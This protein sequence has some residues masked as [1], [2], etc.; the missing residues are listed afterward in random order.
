MRVGRWLDA[1]IP[2]RADHAVVLN[3]AAVETL[4]GFGCRNVS[5]VPPGLDASDLEG[6]QA[7]ELG[8]GPW[9]VY[10]GNPDR[11]QDLDVLVEAM[12]LLP[13]VGLLMVSAS[14]LDD[15]KD[16]G[17]KRLQLVQT[18]DFERVK[19]LVAAADV[20][21]IPRTVCSG[22][23]IKLLNSLGLGVP[24][25][26]A[27]GSSQPLPGV[28]EVPNGD[29]PEMA[30]AI[31]SLVGDPERLIEL[32]ASARAHIREHCTWDARARELEGIYRRVVSGP[33]GQRL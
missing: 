21:A 33:D 14:P 6:V 25:V 18:G 3:A 12:R 10:A 20:A 11:Y 1:T 16:C 30:K 22:Y 24:T 17:L 26:V 8:P 27:A 31:A 15:W 9:V 4:E 19:A 29:A 5:L 13:D 32:G 2:K 28:I 7:A 23:P